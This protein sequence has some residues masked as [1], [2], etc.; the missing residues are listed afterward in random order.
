MIEF[1]QARDRL[2]TLARDRER[3]DGIRADQQGRSDISPCAPA[4]SRSH[5]LSRG[6]A[7]CRAA[8]ARDLELKRRG[9][10]AKVAR[11]SCPNPHKG[12]N[13]MST[14]LFFPGVSG[15]TST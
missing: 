12:V 6:S 11:S 15:Y 1:T 4:R 3:P 10:V 14:V 8:G 2:K 13:R 7:R 9:D 5:R